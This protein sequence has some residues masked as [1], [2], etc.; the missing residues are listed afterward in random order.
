MS[1]PILHMKYNFRDK[2]K[3]SFLHVYYYM[4]IYHWKIIQFKKHFV[5]G[6]G[7]GFGLGLWV[8]LKQVSWLRS[9]LVNVWVRSK[10]EVR[11]SVLRNLV[12]AG[13]F[14]HTYCHWSMCCQTSFLPGPWIPWQD[15]RSLSSWWT[16][17]LCP[18]SNGEGCS[19]ASSYSHS[20]LDWVS[21]ERKQYDHSS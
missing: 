18:H 16:W 5:R 9:E 14:L 3:E 2:S 8:G 21:A 20:S 1:K 12:S 4:D 7:I 11:N 10:V 15:W 13:K 19:L 17:R 6:T